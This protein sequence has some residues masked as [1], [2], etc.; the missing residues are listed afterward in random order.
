MSVAMPSLEVVTA[1]NSQLRS[2]RPCKSAGQSS[3]A[4]SAKT[5]ERFCSTTMFAAQF[6]GSV[7]SQKLFCCVWGGCQSISG[8]TQHSHTL[9]INYSIQKC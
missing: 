6:V 7:S 4:A 2:V 3:I 5:L 9:Q 8:H 1:V